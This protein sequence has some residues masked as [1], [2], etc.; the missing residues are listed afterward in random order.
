MSAA[1]QLTDV[2]GIVE[3][4]C[5]QGCQDCVT[6]VRTHDPERGWVWVVDDCS[7]DKSLQ[8]STLGELM[9]PF[10]IARESLEAAK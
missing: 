2:G 3:W 9:H 4:F 1:E 5:S 10:A 8:G 7:L 6:V